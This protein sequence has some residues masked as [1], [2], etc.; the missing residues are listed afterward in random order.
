MTHVISFSGG[1]TYAPEILKVTPY[2]LCSSAVPRVSFP[3]K[4]LTDQASSAVAFKVLISADCPL[5]DT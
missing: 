1:S 3:S 5:G 2:T 4:S